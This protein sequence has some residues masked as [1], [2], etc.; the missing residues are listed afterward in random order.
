MQY[1]KTLIAGFGAIAATQLAGQA[2]AQLTLNNGGNPTGAGIPS[3]TENVDFGD[4]DLDGDWDAIFAD[5]GDQGND[6]NR[7]WINRGGLQA[8]PLGAFLDQTATRFPVLLDDSR[9]IEFADIDN[10]GDLDIYS[11][12]TA[13]L[14]NQGNHWWVNN[15]GD[16]GG[17]LGFYTDETTQ[18]WVGLGQAGS[19]IAPGL[20]SGGTFIDWS[21]DCDFG[22]L[23]NDGDLDLAHSTYGGAF[24]G[25]VPTR[26]FLNDGA[27]FFTEFNPTGVQLTGNNINNGTQA[28]W[29]EGVHQSNTTN[30]TG[31][32]SDV[33]NSALD[34]DL[35]DIDGDFDLDMLHGSRIGA[36]RMFTNR[37]EEN[38]GTLA[39]CRD[40]TTAVFPANYWSSDD[41]YEQEMGDMDGDGDL[42]VYGLNWTGFNDR[43]FRNNGAGVYTIL[44]SSLPSS[45]ADDNEGDFIDYDNDGDMD[46]FVAN[47]G[48]LDKLYN[49][50]GTGTL[51]LAQQMGVTAG[52]ARSLD[53]DGADLNGDGAMDVVVAEDGGA[54][55][56]TLANTTGSVD[57][58]APYIPFVENDGNKTAAAGTFPVRAQVYDNAPYY[59]TWYNPTTT[60]VSVNGFNLGSIVSMSSQGQ[61]FRT[62]MPANLVGSVSYR[63]R[64]EDEYGNTGFSG[65]QNYTGSTGLNF[66]VQYGA[67]S[68][69]T[70]GTP[71][72]SALSVAFASSTLYLASDNMTTGTPYFLLVTDASLPTLPLPGIGNINVGGTLLVQVGGIVPAGGDVVLGFPLSATLP[73]GVSLFMQVLAVDGTGGNLLSTSNGLEVITQ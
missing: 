31:A 21:C 24:G 5:G 25:N 57:V 26:I 56:N 10:D 51:A 11:S 30:N 41:N 60:E 36:P 50:N 40:V 23:D 48:G 64:S 35:G 34:I 49:N 53:A 9:D 43:T 27:G 59:I 46:L 71:D 15:G 13:Q 55:N 68:A 22:D 45:G 12:N 33:A 1:R 2:S 52:N 18:R 14:S 19:S 47:F 42:E 38:G 72:L 73:G 69:G 7:I 28:I 6:Q 63:F 29:A 39:R 17:T 4:V 70:S 44:Q 65:F 32:Q 54:A 58:R 16:Q 37:L 3:F 20:V 62:L 67:G 61:I 66:A 8:G